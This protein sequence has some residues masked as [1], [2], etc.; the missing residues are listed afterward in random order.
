[1]AVYPGRR[2]AA[3]A[4]S[5]CPGLTC[6]AP[7]GHGGSLTHGG[8]FGMPVA[9]GHGGSSDAPAD[10]VR[11]SSR[12]E[13]A[14]TNSPG[15]SVAAEPRRAALGR[16]APQD[17]SPRRGTTRPRTGCDHGHCE[18]DVNGWPRFAGLDG[19]NGST[20]F[21]V[22]PAFGRSRRTISWRLWRVC[23]AIVSPFRATD[24]RGAVYPG[25]RSAAAPASLCP[26]LTCFAPSGHGGS[27]THG[28]SFAHGGSFGAWRFFGV[29]ARRGPTVLTPRRGND[30][31]SPGQSVAA[32]PRRPPWVARPRKIH[33][34]EGARQDRERDVITSHCEPD[35]NGWPRFAGFDGQNESATFR[36][37]S[38][39]RIISTLGFSRFVTHLSRPFRAMACNA[40]GCI[41]PGGGGRSPAWPPLCP[42]PTCS[43][44][45]GIRKGVRTLFLGP[46]RGR[47]S[48]T[49]GAR[50]RVVPARTSRR[51][52][53]TTVVVERHRA[54]ARSGA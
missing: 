12:P 41:I 44:P 7:S 22:I 16:N 50:H 15:Q 40:A 54:A 53:P 31:I 30:R 11:P 18:P 2:S 38:G 32:E 23:R 19:E 28:G 46:P 27:L 9:S 47:R 5:L 6:F 21:R 8:S 39:I 17:P 43:A 36:V 34:P 37:M 35:V 4:A 42:G 14:T 49:T 25:R 33:R 20:T 48:R 45:S 1:V 3:A 52:E 10:A 29:P 24:V 26:G 13:G 51:P